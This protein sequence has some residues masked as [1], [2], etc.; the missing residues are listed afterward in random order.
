MSTPF[1]PLSEQIAAK[2]IAD[3]KAGTSVFQMPNNSPNSALPFNLDNGH[4]YAGPSALILLM[5]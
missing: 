1:K 4:R 3:L 2:M 5:Q